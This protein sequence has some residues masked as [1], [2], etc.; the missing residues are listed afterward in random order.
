M[1]LM[2]YQGRF[3]NGKFITSTK[4]NIEIP[5]DTDVVITYLEKEE[6]E[7][8]K[9]RRVKKSLAHFHTFLKM[10]EEDDEELGP[11]FDEILSQRV[12]ITRELDL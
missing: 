10:L 9:Q 11:E 6:T 12:N 2:S 7:E 1:S 4:Q 5:E 8:E 3:K